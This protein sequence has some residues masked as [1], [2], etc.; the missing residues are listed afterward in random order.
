M[1]GYKIA[2]LEDLDD[3]LG[4]YPG[5]M[6]M[7]KNPLE[8]EQVTITHRRMPAGTG[9]KGGRGHRH[10]TQEEIIFVFKGTLQVKVED[11]ILELGPNSAIKISP[12]TK[13]A[14]WN[15]GPEDVE[16]L[17]I[18]TRSADLR[19]EIEFIDGFWPAN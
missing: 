17:I 4:D 9:G 8:S 2:K 11:E 16:L 3:I 7:F 5:E 18:S 6:K 14:V 1:A 12:S 15:E 10:K 13:Q 19:E